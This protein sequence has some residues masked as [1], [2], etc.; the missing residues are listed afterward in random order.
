MK[1]IKNPRG[2]TLLE[3]IISITM[4]AVIVGIALGGMR[5][6]ISTREI[7]EQKA[8]TYQRLRFIGEQISQNIKSLYPLFIKQQQEELFF[9]AQE[10]K[11]EPPKYLAFEGLPDSIRIITSAN[12]L[13]LVKNPPWIHEVR[14][15]LGTHPETLERGIIMMER[16]LAR[17]GAFT[18]VQPGS[19]GV[20]YITLAGEVDHLAFR[21]LKMTR[22]TPE[23][24]EQEEDSSIKYKA[25]WVDTIV[26]KP[27]EEI[28]EPFL[29]ED[30]KTAVPESKDTASLPRAI[31]VSIG[32]NQPAVSANVKEPEIV[33]LPPLLIPLNS[34]IEF[35]RP[36]VETGENEAKKN[37]TT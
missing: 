31:E 2:F 36:P 13:S 12:A 22:K 27:D 37:E 7:G 30:Q 15:Y 28:Q 20:R 33:Y 24:L 34:G 6:G 17:S 29:E 32:L 19:P 26:I 14:F 16:D 35:A 18:E 8:D 21:Y 10:N 9:E 11:N 23:E 5:L 1:R 4:I 25:Q 3:L